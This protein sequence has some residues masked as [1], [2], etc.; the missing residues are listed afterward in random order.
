MSEKATKVGACNTVVRKENGWAGYNTDIEGLKK[1]L[2]EF[3]GT[4]NLHGKKVAIIGAGGAAKAAA[5][6]VWE[7]KGK[8]CVFNRTLASARSLAEKYGFAYSGLS[9]NDQKKLEEYSHLIIQTTP[10][11]KIGRAHV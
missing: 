1:A 5:Y 8:G 3:I 10:V 4:K 7:L 9:M 11:G 2:L 6:V